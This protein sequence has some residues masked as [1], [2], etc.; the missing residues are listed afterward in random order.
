MQPVSYKSNDKIF[1]SP[2]A[3]KLIR[4]SNQ[5]LSNINVALGGRGSG[6][7]GRIVAVDVKKA[8][9]DVSTMQTTPQ[10]TPSQPL[11]IHTKTASTPTVSGVYAD[12][13]VTD[14]AKSLIDRQTYSK[15]TVPHYHVS[16]EI[17]LKELLQIRSR[18]NNRINPKGNGGDSLSVLDFVVKAAAQ[19]MHQVYCFSQFYDAL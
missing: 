2:L 19:T 18:L 15:Q 14:M 4:E 8:L 10:V 9:I 1:A 3:K 5:T 16:V 12:F 11:S 7:N 13:E 6:P 17:N